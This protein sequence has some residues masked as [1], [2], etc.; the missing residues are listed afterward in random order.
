MKRMDVKRE[1]E[2]EVLLG[3]ARWRRR[4]RLCDCRQPYPRACA[5]LADHTATT[6]EPSTSNPSTS[7]SLHPSPSYNAGF[8][9]RP[10]EFSPY[11]PYYGP[12]NPLSYTPCGRLRL[13]AYPAGDRR[14]WPCASRRLAGKW[15]WTLSESLAVL[16]WATALA[17][18]GR[19]RR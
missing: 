15:D 4:M 6:A 3:E 17:P 19:P 10:G 16:R 5:R 8:R 14:T 11:Y 13:S 2:R 1:R 18:V 12:L 7:P 9:R